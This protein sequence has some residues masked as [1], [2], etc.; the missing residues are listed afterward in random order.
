MTTCQQT[1]AAG[2]N[3]YSFSKSVV[4]A[5]DC[6]TKQC[7]CNQPQTIAEKLDKCVVESPGCYTLDTYNAVIT[8]FGTECNFTA[9]LKVRQSTLD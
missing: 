2:T 7:V 5:I 8:F 9:H 3:T 4:G 6:D 1:C